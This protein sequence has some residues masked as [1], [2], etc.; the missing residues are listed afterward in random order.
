MKRIYIET[1][2]VSYLASLPTRDLVKAAR[3]EI[4]WEWWQK[5]RR[6][7]SLF[8]SQVVLEEAQAGDVE[9][10]E[11]RLTYLRELPLLDLSSEA[12]ILAGS[13]IGAG[14][15]PGKAANDALHLALASVHE[16]D[17][18]LTWNCRHLANAA[19]RSALARV[20]FE[21]GFRPPEICTPDELLE[22]YDAG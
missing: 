14:A 20:V 19:L 11:R 18:L 4:T 21:K 3:Q 15:L 22:P 5:R 17:F 7:Y 8:T 12:G 2:V 10:A 6:D 9:A 16:M 1:S 13:L